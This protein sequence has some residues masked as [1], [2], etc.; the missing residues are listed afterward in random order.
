MVVSDEVDDC[1]RDDVPEADAVDE[2]LS[3][4]ADEPDCVIDGVSVVAVLVVVV[5]VADGELAGLGDDDGEGD[6][7][8]LPVPDADGVAAPLG[9]GELL[10]VIDRLRVPDIVAVVDT[11]GVSVCG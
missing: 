1:E 5:G 7:D 6:P 11:D 10:P 4:D 2:R 8:S 9:V 3:V